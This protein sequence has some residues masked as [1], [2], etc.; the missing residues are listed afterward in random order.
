M[1][2]VRSEKSLPNLIYVGTGK[3]GS[4]WLHYV[5]GKHPEVYLT[6]VKE[7]NFFDLNFDKGVKWYMSFFCDAKEEKLIGEVA[8]RYFRNEHVAYRMKRTLV[9]PKIIIGLRDPSSYFMSDYLY[10]KKNGMFVGDTAEYARERFSWDVLEYK[11]HLSKFLL[12]FPKDNIF[13][14][15]FNLLKTSPKELYT[16]LCLFL[17]ISCDFWADDFAQ[18]V[19]KAA[20]A[21]FPLVARL[22]KLGSISLKRLGGQKFIA[23]V[24]RNSI[25]KRVVYREL[26]DQPVLDATVE[27]RLLDVSRRNVEWLDQIFSLGL[28]RS[29]GYEK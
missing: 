17:D 9:D 24:K 13:V 12:H 22:L 7:T 15:D 27:Q 16:E 28:L 1:T 5:L 25:L 19:N 26:L 11:K 29:W 23:A 21:R 3:A 14:Y 20:S 10:A 2:I 18:P 8:H 6:S 4:T